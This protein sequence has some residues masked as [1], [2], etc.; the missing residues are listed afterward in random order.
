MVYV[1][2]KKVVIKCQCMVKPQHIY[3]SYTLSWKKANQSQ[4]YGFSGIEVLKYNYVEI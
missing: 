4:M 3:G 1:E 2:S